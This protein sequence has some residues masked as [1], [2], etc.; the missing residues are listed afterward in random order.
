V[1]LLRQRVWCPVERVECGEVVDAVDVG[2]LANAARVEA[3]EVESVQDVL[4]QEYAQDPRIVNSGSA[5]ASRVHEERP[6]A[7][8]RHCGGQPRERDIYLSIAGAGVIQGHAKRPA[9]EATA[10]VT[11]HDCAGTLCFGLRAPMRSRGQDEK[12]DKWHDDGT[13]S[14]EATVPRLAGVRTVPTV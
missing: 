14:H 6:N 12:D 11:P 5:W 4:R 2:A 13:G 9:F 3:D 10:A 7:L 8:R 1:L